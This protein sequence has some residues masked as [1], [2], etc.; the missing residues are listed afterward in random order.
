[1]PG[2][3]SQGKIPEDPLTWKESGN[4]FF[5]K[6]QYEEAIRCYVHAIELDPDFLDAWNNMGF[7]LRKLGKLSEARQCNEK[8]RQLRQAQKPRVS[9]PAIQSAEMESTAKEIER[10]DGAGKKSGT[11]ESQSRKTVAE[12]QERNESPE[13]LVI[14]IDLRPGS[15]PVAAESQVPTPPEP[16]IRI[17]TD[18]PL[19][20]GETPIWSGRM[21]WAANW[22]WF[23]LAVVFC[24][25]IVLP[26]LFV[27]I[28]WRN[29]AG[30]EYFISDRR[31]HSRYGL[32]SHVTQE[33]DMESIRSTSIRQ[34]FFGRVFNFGDILIAAPGTPAGAGMFPG[35]AEP[36]KIRGII[37]KQIGNQKQ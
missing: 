9:G 6:G 4:D 2:E 16:G 26:I 17:P 27:V 36:M 29:V 18:I 19:I 1:M 23:L 14:P 3:N 5:N 10:T 31:V 12:P 28:A 34:G 37:E 22:V 35:S 20:P 7:S 24:W 11:E 30:S 32:F 15:Q 21:S 25:T 8:V 33:L 13:A